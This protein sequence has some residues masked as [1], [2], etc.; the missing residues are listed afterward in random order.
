MTRTTKKD[1][2]C[3]FNR[4][5]YLFGKNKA[6]SYKDV[7]SWRLNYGD[8]YGGWVIQE[9]NCK[10][11]SITHPFGHLRRK[12]SEFVDWASA[13]TNAIAVYTGDYPNLYKN[14]EDWKRDKNNRLLPPTRIDTQL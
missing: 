1:V 6:T 7:G 8:C 13:I 9:I 4:L 12:A 3:Q 14:K 5:L 10:S 11:G 2:E